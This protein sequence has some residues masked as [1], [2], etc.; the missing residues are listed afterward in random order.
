MKSLKTLCC[1]QIASFVQTLSIKDAAS[2]LQDAK[3]DLLY[4]IS[5]EFTFKSFS[6]L[7]SCL[8]FE[9]PESIV[10]RQL[11]NPFVYH[12]ALRYEEKYA[13]VRSLCNVNIPA[14]K[15]MI[16]ISQIPRNLNILFPENEVNKKM[17]LKIYCF[18]LSI[19]KKINYCLEAFLLNNH[20]FQTMRLL[21]KDLKRLVEIFFLKICLKILL[22]LEVLSK[23]EF[24][25]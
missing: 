18:F 17:F 2:F 8:L 16:P 6:F 4:E 15:L 22:F 25:V 5:N 20:C 11:C 3:P 24:C 9:G 7:N 14:P 19:W 1:K 13:A 10:L 21:K 12:R 23:V